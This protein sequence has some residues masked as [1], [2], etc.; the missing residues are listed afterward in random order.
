MNLS[1]LSEMSIKETIDYLTTELD[2]RN[3]NPFYFQEIKESFHSTCTLKFCVANYLC[4]AAGASNV[5]KIIAGSGDVKEFLKNV[6]FNSSSSTEAILWVLKQHLKKQ[7]ANKATFKN[8]VADALNGDMA[9]QF[10]EG[11]EEAKLS[12]FETSLEEELT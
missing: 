12:S 9:Q 2:K 6:S 7:T 1:K 8:K 5:L 10:N 11:M 4:G 3:E